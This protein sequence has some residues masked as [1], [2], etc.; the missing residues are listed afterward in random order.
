MSSFGGETGEFLGEERI[1]EDLGVGDLGRDPSGC[2]REERGAR[3]GDAPSQE[4]VGVAEGVRRAD[5]VRELEERVVGRQRLGVD[6][7]EP[8]TGEAALPQRRDERVLIDDRSPR[9]VDEERRRLQ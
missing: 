8:R 2:A 7:V 4:L 9:H 6:D 1:V 3:P 5:D